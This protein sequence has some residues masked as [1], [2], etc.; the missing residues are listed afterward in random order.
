MP[1]QGL[2]LIGRVIPKLWPVNYQPMT[3]SVAAV[4]VVDGGRE[5]QPRSPL[6]VF[7][8]LFSSLCVFPCEKAKYVGA[9]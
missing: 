6:R 8:L 9:N 1:F 7:S 2:I 4:G 3:G 5:T